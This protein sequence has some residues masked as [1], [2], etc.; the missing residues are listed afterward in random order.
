MYVSR[1]EDLAT[2]P[3][4]LEHLRKI[5]QSTQIIQKQIRFARDYQDIG[6]HPPTVAEW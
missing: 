1:A 2:D 5:E 4:L 6:L 3:A